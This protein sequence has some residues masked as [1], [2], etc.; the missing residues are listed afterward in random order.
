MKNLSL[1]KQQVQTI[2]NALFQQQDFL[3]DIIESTH[4]DINPTNK[5]SSKLKNLDT[6]EKLSK[7]KSIIA[8]F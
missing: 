8:K 1:N 3:E 2:L 6:K 4:S 5:E 7:L